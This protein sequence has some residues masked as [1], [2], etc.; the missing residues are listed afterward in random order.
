MVA[1][2]YYLMKIDVSMDD[3]VPVT[4]LTNCLIS[5]YCAVVD[6]CDPTSLVKPTET[7]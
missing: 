7:K 5:I 1:H 2:A 6:R 4:V 3:A